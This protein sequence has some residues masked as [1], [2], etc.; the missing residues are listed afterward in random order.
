MG[1]AC[2]TPFQKADLLGAG[3]VAGRTVPL[4]FAPP[5]PALCAHDA[6]GLCVR[7]RGAGV[8]NQSLPT[9]APPAVEAAPPLRLPGRE[10]PQRPGRPQAEARTRDGLQ[11]AKTP[12]G[13]RGL[14]PP[15][16]PPTAACTAGRS[17]RCPASY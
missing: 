17:S 7:G 8:V 10:G 6:H 5:Q 2:S 11:P 16:L 4:T 15:G 3:T 13:K 14:G 1:Q 12:R 9:G